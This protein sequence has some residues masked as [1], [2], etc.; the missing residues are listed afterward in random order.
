MDDNIEILGTCLYLKKEKALVIADLHI[1]YEEYLNK[2]G[3]LVPRFQFGETMEALDKL[4]DGRDFQTVIINGDL[5]HE[6]GS[7]SRTEW[8]QTLRI[9]DYLSEISEKIVLVKG[10]HD[11]ILG[12]IAKRRNLKTVDE[13][14]LGKYFFCHGHQMPEVIPSNSTL[15]IGHE[16]PAV[17]IRDG[18]RTEVFKCFIEG[19]CEGRRIIVMPSSNPVVE[20]SNLLRDKIL[21]PVLKGCELKEF[22]VYVVSDKIYDFGR[23]RDLL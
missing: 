12:P 14:Q 22:K 7:I 18:V 10:N 2:T 19:E 4:T 16:H 23:V 15:I 9:L 11:T 13:Y 3:V 21:S 6:F 20:G 17:G 5:K 8:R 1:G